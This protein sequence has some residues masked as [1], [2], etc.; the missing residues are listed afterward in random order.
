MS[1]DDLTIVIGAGQAGLA[2]AHHLARRGI[3]YVVLDAHE[4]VGDSWRERYDSLRL[5]TPAHFD[6]LPGRR[7]PASS[8]TFPTGHEMADYLEDYA[9]PLDVRTGVTVTRVR[10]DGDG[11]VVESTGGTFHAAAVVVASGGPAGAWVPELDADLDDS[12]VRLHS[13]RY[14]SPADLAPGPVLV[15]GASHS[16]ADLALEA[17]HAGHDTYLSGRILGEVPIPLDSRRMRVG[18]YAIAFAA[19]HV[20]TLRTPMGRR[21]APGVRH[22][23]APLLR[24]KLADLDAAGVHRTASRTV[25]TRDG[26]PVLDDGTVLDVRNVLWCT[27][28]REDWSWVE[29]AVVGADGYP[30]Q[31]RGVSG[32]GGLFFVGLPFQYAFASGMVHGVGRDAAYVARHV[33]AHVRDVR[34]DRVGAPTARAVAA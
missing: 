25:G 14:R 13:S 23:G 3:P 1:G 9:R 8:W 30:V 24:V 6:S 15:V 32:T 19:R 28:F 29:P 5:F 16:G 7:F 34:A 17:A 2:T 22:G 21:M 26:Q 33:V 18:G 12:I 27:G 31:Q 20:L 10:A 11:F 4:R